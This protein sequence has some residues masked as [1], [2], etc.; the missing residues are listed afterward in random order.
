VRK[1]SLVKVM[2]RQDEA[3]DDVRVHW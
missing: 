1:Q 2:E 3:R